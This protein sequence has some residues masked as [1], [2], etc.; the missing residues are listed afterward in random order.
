MTRVWLYAVLG[1]AALTNATGLFVT[2]LEPDSALY[3]TIAKTMVQRQD[4]VNLFVNGEDWLDKPHFPFWLT[5]ISFGIFGFSTWAYKLPALILVLAGAFYTY[6]FAKLFYD[7]RVALVAAIILLTAQHIIISSSDVRAEAYL[8]AFVIG[9][10]Y[11]FYQASRLGS[12]AH[13]VAG[14]LV[15]AAAVMTKGIFALIPIG[16]SIAGGLLLSRQWTQA[17]HVRWLAAILLILLFIT[18][19]L[20]CLWQQFDAHPEKFVLGRTGVSG[21]RFFFWDSQFGRFFNTGPIRG[22]GNPFQYLHV[23]LWAFLPWSVPLFAATY[24]AIRKL[25]SRQPQTAEYFNLSGGVLTFLLFSFSQFQL[26]HYLN[27]AFPFF[28]IMT[29][30]Y[31]LGLTTPTAVRWASAWQWFIVGA[32]LVVCMALQLLVRP[33]HWAGPA[34]LLGMAALLLLY[35]QKKPWEQ[36]QARLIVSLATASI[37]ANLYLNGYIVPALMKYQAGSE[38]AFYLNSHYPGRPVMQLGNA[39]S[40]ALEFYLQ[41]PVTTVDVSFLQEGR[42]PQGALV[43]ASASVLRPL[44]NEF[45]LLH[46]TPSYPVSRPTLTFL[47]AATRERAIGESWLVQVRNADRIGG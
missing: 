30:A 43:Y 39:Y 33:G 13:L 47:N 2:I 18:P 10:V 35:L 21:L 46:R 5:A 32:A 24:D 14:S 25:I 23:V 31:I 29:A 4:F 34:A 19:E 6:A 45:Q 38:M 9:A 11:H 12:H 40:Y 15:A 8:T 17:F 1:L 22:Q 44:S 16:G 20:F 27:I 26:P 3:A 7:R 37:F 36:W 41:A 28:A 42:L